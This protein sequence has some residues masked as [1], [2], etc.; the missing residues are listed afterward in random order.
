ME[1]IIDK[2][3]FSKDESSFVLEWYDP[4]R[5]SAEVL[6]EEFE[7]KYEAFF[8]TDFHI[9]PEFTVPESNDQLGIHCHTLDKDRVLEI[10]DKI[11]VKMLNPVKNDL[12]PLYHASLNLLLRLWR[13]FLIQFHRQTKVT[14]FSGE[15]SGSPV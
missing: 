11:D 2:T 9:K 14:F 12:V 15:T 5:F 8:K 13:A 1:K 4:K 6:R 10:L 3:D 7:S